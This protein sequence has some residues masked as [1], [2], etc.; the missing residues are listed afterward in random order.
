MVKEKTAPFSRAHHQIRKK[1]QTASLDVKDLRTTAQNSGVNLHLRLHVCRPEKM[2]SFQPR[3]A[4]PCKVGSILL[5][6][7]PG[8]DFRTLGEGGLERK[9]IHRARTKKKLEPKGHMQTDATRTQ[10]NNRRANRTSMVNTLPKPI[11]NHSVHHKGFSMHQQRGSS[12]V[13]GWCQT[14]VRKSV[15]FQKTRRGDTSS[16]Q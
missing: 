14:H 9:I 11:T 12:R 1:H 15:L 10:K 6:M 2:S 16:K 8:D 5:S 3:S 7:Q 13:S 4:C